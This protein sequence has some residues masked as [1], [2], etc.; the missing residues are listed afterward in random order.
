[1]PPIHGRLTELPAQAYLTAVALRREVDQSEL[2]VFQLAS[3][4]FKFR[5]K[6]GQSVR[7]VDVTPS[8]L[9]GPVGIRAV[10]QHLVGVM[11]PAEF[12][13]MTHDVSHDAL[14]EYKCPVCLFGREIFFANRRRRFRQ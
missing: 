1:M 4:P 12:T 14:D 9:L 11:E 2:E 6:L 3:D 13:V 8:G 5:A 10:A 7:H